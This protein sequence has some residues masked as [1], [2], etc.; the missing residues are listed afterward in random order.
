MITPAINIIPANPIK[1]G[2]GGGSQFEYTAIDNI[3]S[4][5]F[6]GTS[7]YILAPTLTG[8]GMGTT[9]KISVSLWLK[10]NTA[11]VTPVAFNTGGW[12]L[13]SGVCI[14]FNSTDNDIY[15]RVNNT[16]VSTSG[17]N[18]RDNNWHHVVIC[19]NGSLGSDQ[20]E[21]FVNGQSAA[22]NTKTGNISGTTFGTFIG[23]NTDLS[24]GTFYGFEGRL[25]EVAIWNDK[26]SQSTIEAIYNTTNNNPGKVADLLE[27]PEGAPVAWYRM[28][29]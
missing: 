2:G 19:Y 13:T 20:I 23:S 16:I 25:D 6:D 8:L 28:G 18:Y 15:S 10:T 11:K 9:D 29:N 4:M 22:T 21:L 1:S 3:Y 27:T 5:E 26:L 17:T 24:T 7:D 14:Y 12:P